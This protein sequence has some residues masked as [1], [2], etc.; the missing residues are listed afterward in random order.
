MYSF[1]TNILSWIIVLAT[2]HRSA[3]IHMA[4]NEDKHLMLREKLSWLG[5]KGG[6]IAE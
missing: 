2:Y 4:D 5:S 3:S 1:L 6:S